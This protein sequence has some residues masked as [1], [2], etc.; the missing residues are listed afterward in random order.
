MSTGKG[1]GKGNLDNDSG[2]SVTAQRRFKIKAKKAAEGMAAQ[3]AYERAKR[4]KLP[5]EEAA[6]RLAEAAAEAAEAA[7][8][9]SSIGGNL[10]RHL[11]DL[12]A[13]EVSWGCLLA[14]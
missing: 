6:R 2:M 11:S 3:A 8:K 14:L 5:P 4:Q 1:Q 13:A 7:G 10:S 12:K 9:S